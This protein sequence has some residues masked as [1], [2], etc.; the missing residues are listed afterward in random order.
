MTCSYGDKPRCIDS[1]F[2]LLRGYRIMANAYRRSYFS[3]TGGSG[4]FRPG[5]ALRFLATGAV[6]RSEIIGAYL[7]M[8]EQK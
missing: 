2:M 6:A 5:M 3:F 4:R 1:A 7:Q 8:I